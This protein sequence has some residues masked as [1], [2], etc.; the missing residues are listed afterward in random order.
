MLTHTYAHILTHTHAHLHTHTLFKY[1]SGVNDTKVIN[2]F[3]IYI[4]DCII[5]VKFACLFCIVF[6]V[7]YSV[8]S[9]MF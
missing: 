7:V 1:V 5:V 9:T 2:L 3:Q 8:L 6:I 4:V